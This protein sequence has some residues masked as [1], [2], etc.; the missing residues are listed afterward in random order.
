MT[1]PKGTAAPAKPVVG[2]LFYIGDEYYLLRCHHF[3]DVGDH[4]H[5]VFS[6][7]CP[8]GLV[9]ETELSSIGDWL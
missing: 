9:P 8:H 3:E 4:D 6:E 7:V 1:T 2:Y 5:T